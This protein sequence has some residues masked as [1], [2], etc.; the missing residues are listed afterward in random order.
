IGSGPQDDGHGRSGLGPLATLIIPQ[1]FV[2][3]FLAVHSK[4]GMLWV[5]AQRE[6]VM[7]IPSKCAPHEEEEME[8]FQDYEDE[9]QGDLGSKLDDFDEDPDDDDDDDDEDDVVEETIVVVAV[10]IDSPLAPVIAQD[11]IDEESLAEPEPPRK[12]AK[13][14]AKAAK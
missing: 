9:E 2:Q 4:K 6:A 5:I 11:S 13:K 10:P 12:P 8:D 14:A 3:I 1:F 7:L